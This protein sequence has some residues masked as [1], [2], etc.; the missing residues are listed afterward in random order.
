M[1]TVFDR[2]LVPI[3]GSQPSM[4]AAQVAIDIAREHHSA[5]EGLYVVD[6]QVLDALARLTERRK[7]ELQTELQTT[8]RRY[9]NELSRLARESGLTAEQALHEGAPYDQ[10][11]AEAVRWHATLIVMGRVGRHGARRILL[12]ST[13]ERV[14]EHGQTPVLVVPAAHE[15]TTAPVA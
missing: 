2:I 13:T 3:D 4:Q 15:G 14:L 5:L 7:S 8:G 6:T 12:G 11:L 10:I 9:L 1:T